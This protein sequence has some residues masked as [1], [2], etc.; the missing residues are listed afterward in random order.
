MSHFIQ[1]SH[2]ECTTPKMYTYNIFS[3]LQHDVTA[4]GTLNCIHMLWVLYLKFS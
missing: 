4:C 2:P 3:I 1:N